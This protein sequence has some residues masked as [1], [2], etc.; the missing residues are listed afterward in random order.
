MGEVGLGGVFAGLGAHPRCT[1][2]QVSAE[3]L[4]PLLKGANEEAQ[5]TILNCMFA[6]AG[7]GPRITVAM[8]RDMSLSTRVWAVRR[9]L[10]HVGNPVAVADGVPEYIEQALSSGEL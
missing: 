4:P 9:L 1:V 3:M 7:W 10:P 6:A 5:L 2:V 8:L